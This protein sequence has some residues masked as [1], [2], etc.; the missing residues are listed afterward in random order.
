MPTLSFKVTTREAARIRKLARR[1]HVTLAEYL[2]RRVV[3]TPPVDLGGG[4]RIATSPVTG[5]PV[6][7]S[8]PDVHVT[9]EQIRA[10]LADFP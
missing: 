2:R 4:Y 7:I 10:L 1:Q 6:M 9:S 5:L 3:E 8:P